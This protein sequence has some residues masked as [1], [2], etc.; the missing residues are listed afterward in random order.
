MMIVVGAAAAKFVQLMR[1]YAGDGGGTD[2]LKL[3]N[4]SAASSIRVR[5]DAA[6]GNLKTRKASTIQPDVHFR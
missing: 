1:D 3:L 5:E 4:H 6:G 2:C